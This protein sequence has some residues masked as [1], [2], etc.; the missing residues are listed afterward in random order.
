MGWSLTAAGIL[1]GCL[2]LSLTVELLQYVGLEE[3][4]ATD[5]VPLNMLGVAS[6]YLLGTLV[7]R[8]APADPAPRPRAGLPRT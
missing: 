3:V 4:A 7:L 2:A 8:A 5:D 1:L 6:G